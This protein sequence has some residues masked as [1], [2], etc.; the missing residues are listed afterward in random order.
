MN[1]YGV[2]YTF[3]EW[4]E[5]VI[6]QLA[7]IDTQWRKYEESDDMVVMQQTLKKIAGYLIYLPRVLAIARGFSRERQRVYV[8][9]LIAASSKM[10]P[11]VMRDMQKI[12]AN[13]ELMLSEWIDTLNGNLIQVC[14]S[15][16]TSISSQ[17]KMAP[18]PGNT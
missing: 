4:K 14:S 6:I 17:K 11:N 15:L 8:E 13:E 18:F 7:E 1:I 9:S 12:Y 10:S 3:R 16:Q 5:T 2:K